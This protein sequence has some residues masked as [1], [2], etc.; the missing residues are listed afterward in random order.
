M[1]ALGR[2]DDG[3]EVVRDGKAVL[4]PPATVN[5]GVVI[6]FAAMSSTCRRKESSTMNESS[7]SK[8]SDMVSLM[9][10]NLRSYHGLDS[11]PAGYYHIMDILSFQICLQEFK[12]QTSRRL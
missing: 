3:S 2:L 5:L 1:T 9:L 4:M 6:A 10:E 11:S 8:S 12:E 7:S